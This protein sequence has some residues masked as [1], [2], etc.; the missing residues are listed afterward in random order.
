MNASLLSR[1]PGTLPIT[2]GP[3]RSRAHLSKANGTA[4]EPK[5]GGSRGRVES[6]AFLHGAMRL[7]KLATATDSGHIA[8]T[9]SQQGYL[10]VQRGTSEDLSTATEQGVSFVRYLAWPGSGPAQ[11]VEQ[12]QD[13]VVEGFAVVGGVV[14]AAPGTRR[15]PYLE[16]GASKIE[17][18]RI[19]AASPERVEENFPDRLF[20]LSTLASAR[21][22]Y[23]AAFDSLTRTV[24][25]CAVPQMGSSL[26]ILQRPA[27]Q[28]CCAHAMRTGAAVALCA[29]RHEAPHIDQRAGKVQ[30]RLLASR[31]E[32]GQHGV[33][34]QFLRPNHAPRFEHI[35][36]YQRYMFLHRCCT[37]RARDASSVHHLLTSARCSQLAWQ[38]IRC[39]LWQMCQT[40]DERWLQLRLSRA[41]RSNPQDRR[42]DIAGTSLPL[43][44]ILTIWATAPTPSRSAPKARIRLF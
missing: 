10:P 32:A 1:D 41:P 24:A 31:A 43:S 22:T 12:S 36:S 28:I 7:L 5:S 6:L 15:Q 13:A 26:A 30:Q 42:Y 11:P 3:A 17:M 39:A 40:A 16:P 8:A 18:L 4:D 2:A 35:S 33:V 38:R 9:A 14:F 37:L 20:I 44:E 27:S 19:L 23:F 34:G 25:P 21:R 29:S